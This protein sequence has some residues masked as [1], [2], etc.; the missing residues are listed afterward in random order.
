MQVSYRNVFDIHALNLT[1]DIQRTLRAW[2]GMENFR[3]SGFLASFPSRMRATPTTTAQGGTQ[4]TTGAPSTTTTRAA[5]TDGATNSALGG[6]T[7]A[8]HSLPSHW[9]ETALHIFF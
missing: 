8:S 1:I 6:D 5:T 4:M 3:I 9:H 2:P 7:Q